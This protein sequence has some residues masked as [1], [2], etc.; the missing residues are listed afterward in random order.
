[1]RV[2][3]TATR[4]TRGFYPSKHL[5]LNI[6]P[7]SNFVPMRARSWATVW[8]VWSLHNNA[9]RVSLR[10]FD[11][12]SSPDQTSL[13]KGV[14]IV[15]KMVASR[16]MQRIACWLARGIA[17]KSVVDLTVSS[18]TPTASVWA[19][20]SNGKV[21]GQWMFAMQVP[22]YIYVQTP[23]TAPIFFPRILRSIQQQTALVA[24]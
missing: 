13:F 2:S 20:A 19:P 14:I 5:L 1:M 11:E 17:L 21:E 8:Q 7:A 22:Y 6:I 23:S 10:L 12:L 16:W 18:Y 9:V 15:S 3:Q 4:V 24:M